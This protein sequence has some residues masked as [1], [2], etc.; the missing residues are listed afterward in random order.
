MDIRKIQNRGIVEKM[1]ASLEIRF[2]G[3]RRTSSNV[4]SLTGREL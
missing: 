1:L 3:K 4:L 2:L